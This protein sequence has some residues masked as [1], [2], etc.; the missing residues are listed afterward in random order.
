MFSF[1]SDLIGIMKL[2][3]LRQYNL[4]KFDETGNISLG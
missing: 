2:Y 1:E 4:P 3:E